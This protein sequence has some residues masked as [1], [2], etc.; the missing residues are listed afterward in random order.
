MDPTPI[1]RSRRRAIAALAL[2]L[3]P[4][5]CI[6][7]PTID[8]ATAEAL[9][10]IG[11]ELGMIRDENAQLQFQVDSLRSALA[12]QDTVLRQLANLSGIPVRP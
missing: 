6:G 7:N 9:D 2:A 11:N 5:G 1:W 10:E 3:L 12:R 4:I 8:A